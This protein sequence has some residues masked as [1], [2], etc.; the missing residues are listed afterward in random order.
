MTGC[1]PSVPVQSNIT[2]RS[3]VTP[4]VIGSGRAS[5]IWALAGAAPSP[6]RAEVAAT[7]RAPV[8]SWVLR[9]TESLSVGGRSSVDEHRGYAPSPGAVASDLR[10]HVEAADSGHCACDTL[11]M[12]KSGTR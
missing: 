5:R 6:M 8:M 9:M 10:R 12:L 7:A 2:P 4:G 11:D 1:L 3:W